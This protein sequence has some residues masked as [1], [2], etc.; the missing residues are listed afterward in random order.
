[1][2]N[3]YSLENKVEELHHQIVV[4]SI[5]FHMPKF[6]DQ[7]RI[8]IHLKKGVTCIVFNACQHVH[9]TISVNVYSIDPP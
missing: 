3:F 4:R 9:L 5:L 1:M 2:I 6:F 8:I 7:Y